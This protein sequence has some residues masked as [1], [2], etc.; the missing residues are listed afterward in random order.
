MAAARRWTHVI[1]FIL[2][3]DGRIHLGQIDRKKPL[4]IRLAFLEGKEVEAN[5]ISRSVFDGV[6]TDR[7]L[8]VADTPLIPLNYRDHANEANMAIPDLAVVISKE[9]RDVPESE[10]YNY[11]LSNTSSNDVSARAQQR[12]NSQW[13]LSKGLDGETIFD[14]LKTI[15]FLSQGTTL[16][17]GTVILT[18]TGPGIGMVRSQRV[19]VQDIGTLVNKVHHE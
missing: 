15:A 12:T 3:E 11:F 8:H 4:D 16:E 18:G 6:V 5:C 10:A 9:C 1:R 7:K 17:R 14:I 13:R 19:Y 2:K